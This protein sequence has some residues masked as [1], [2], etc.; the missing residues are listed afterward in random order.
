MPLLFSSVMLFHS[1]ELAEAWLG[2]NPRA[3]AA[4][5]PEPALPPPAAVQRVA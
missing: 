2:E 4:F 5:W 1:R 3:M